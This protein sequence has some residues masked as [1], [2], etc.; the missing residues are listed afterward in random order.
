MKRHT[1]D[2]LPHRLPIHSDE[3]ALLLGER[4]FD[5]LTTEEEEAALKRYVA[6]ETAADDARFNELRAVMGFAAKCRRTQKCISE[7]C[8]PQQS[9]HKRIHPAVRWSVAAAV[10]AVV[11]TSA[12]GTFNYRQHNECVAYI[13]GQRTTDTELVMQAM[14]ASMAKMDRADEETEMEAQ[15]NDMFNTIDSDHAE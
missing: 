2:P 3:E 1:K 8:Q 15:L 10:T 12:W 5:A 9:V 11:L 13:D 14:E 4:Y 7:N 6:F